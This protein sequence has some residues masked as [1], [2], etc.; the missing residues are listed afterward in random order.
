MLTIDLSAVPNTQDQDDQHLIFDFVH[1]PVVANTDTV[2]ICLPAQLFDAV[3]TRMVNEIVYSPS[4]P[5]LERPII[6]RKCARR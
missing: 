6:L 5:S 4:Y 2:T 1:D 3:C